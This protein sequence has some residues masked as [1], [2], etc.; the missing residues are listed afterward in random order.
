MLKPKVKMKKIIYSLLIAV[1]ACLLASCMEID[2]FDAPDA[3]VTG[4]IIDATTGQNMML[5]QAH[6][7]IRIWER[8]FTGRPD[9]VHQS[10]P[11]QQNGTYNNHRLFAGTYDMLPFG[12][13]IW[14]TDTVFHVPIGRRT[15]TQDFHV[16][17]LLRLVDF[18]VSFT[19]NNDTVILSSRIY[20]PATQRTVNIHGVPTVMNL[21][22]LRRVRPMV[23][24]LYFTGP[25]QENPAYE[26]P[27]F[28]M[29]FAGTGLPWANID[30]TGDG[31]SNA[32]L[33]DTSFGAAARPYASIEEGR[34]IF[35]LPIPASQRGQFFNF[36]MGARAFDTEIN[37]AERYNLSEIKRVW[38]PR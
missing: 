10:I 12:L 35:R 23:S 5:S 38:V 27:R 24:F 13:P 36:R 30:T 37:T 7:H 33:P 15:V 8:S 1:S 14:P 9:A 34:F 18:D 19:A 20:A 29:D 16:Y 32:T 11:V 6:G 25:G 22:P 17:P 26:A 4:R 28:R 31:F 3:H 2:N 21:P